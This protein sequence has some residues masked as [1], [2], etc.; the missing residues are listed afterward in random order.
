MGEEQEYSYACGRDEKYMESLVTEVE[1][2]VKGKSVQKEGEDD[3]GGSDRDTEMWS[4]SLSSFCRDVVGVRRHN[5][6]RT[7]ASTRSGTI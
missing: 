4:F 1:E 5:L 3:S 2:G 7:S 6:L